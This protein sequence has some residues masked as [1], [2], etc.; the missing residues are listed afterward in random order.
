M[1]Y[2]HCR[3]TRAAKQTLHTAL[4]VG[5][6]E[7]YQSSFVHVI[8]STPHKRA[9]QQYST[10]TEFDAMPNRVYDLAVLYQVCIL[11]LLESDYLLVLFLSKVNYNKFSSKKNKVMG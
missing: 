1:E 7:N 9:L 2:R 8:N 6:R 10:V 4:A 11:I 5:V 3:A